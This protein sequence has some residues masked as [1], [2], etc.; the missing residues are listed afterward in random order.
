MK[1]IKLSRELC[2]VLGMLIMPF[3]VSLTIKADLGMSM[4]AAPSYIISER[5]PFITTGQTEW[6]MQAL[7]I[8]LMC[9]IIKKFRLTYLTSFLSA[10]IYGILLDFDIYIT[11]FFQAN[12][13]ALRIILLLAG[14]VLTSLSVALFFNTYLAPCAYD[15]FVR[16]VGEEKKLDMRKWKLCYDFAMLIAS[17]LLSLIL[18]KR[19]I[20][21]NVG[22]LIMAVFNGNIIAFFSKLINKHFTLFDRFPLRK[23]FE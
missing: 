20:A 14:M 2:Y 1:K 15:Y 17:V 22:T 13:V 12:H 10:F 18:F 8:V 6:I 5:A 16:N 23:Y 11:G 4:I 21:I 3:A 19:L 9:V 7:F